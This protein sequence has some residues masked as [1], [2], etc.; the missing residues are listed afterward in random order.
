MSLTPL[1]DLDM[2]QIA[3]LT[4]DEVQRY[5]DLACAEAGV[6]LS[7]P[8][9]APIP[10]CKAIPDIVAYQVE[11]LI[12]ES[13][14]DAR[15]VATLAAS[16]PMLERGTR[17]YNWSVHYA[18]PRLEP[19]QVKPLRLWSVS[20]YQ[21]ARNEVEAHAERERAY[22]KEMERYRTAEKAR[23]PHEETVRALVRQARE[24]V[25]RHHRFV[26]EFRRYIDLA[27]DII[28]A[29]NFFLLAHADIVE[30][31][32]LMRSIETSATAADKGDDE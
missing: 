29:R 16:F 3:A 4:E 9:P 11:G 19:P 30:G 1:R 15:E 31:S 17:D 20:G 13:E 22:A 18:D 26:D 8:K 12:F 23:K 10:K 25:D 5:I 14:D 27:D 28:V 2:F 21:I 32:A 6:C 24:Y 7:P